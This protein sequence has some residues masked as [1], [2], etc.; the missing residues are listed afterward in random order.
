[1]ASIVQEK[2]EQA[3]GILQELR[4]DAWMTFVRETPASGDPVLPLIYGH[5][6]TWQSAIILTRSGERIAIIGQYEAETVHQTG[7]YPTVIPYHKSVR[8][9][10]LTVLDLLQPETIAINYSKNDVLADGLDHGL[11]LVLLDLLEGT[12]W[13]ERLISAEQVIAALRGRKTPTEV[14][15]IR[16]AVRTTAEIYQRTFDFVQVGM[17]EKQIAGFMH[18][19]MLAQGLDPAWELNN[20]PAVNAGPKSLMG[21]IGPSDI[22][23][24]RGHILHFDFGVRQQEYCADIQRVMYFLRS[25]ESQAPQP[26]QRGFDVIVRAI[27][28]AAAVMKPGI[29]GKQVDAV[30]R[31]VVTSAG[32]PE[33]MYGTGHHLGRLAHD[34]AGLLGPEWERY[35]NSPN[36]PLELGQ[37]Y[38]IEPGLEVPG[39]GY[40]GIEEDVIVTENGAEFL[41]LPQT[42][43]LLR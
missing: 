26:V 31:E 40:I 12:P 37:V 35:G 30:A 9:D 36:Y 18:E 7:A 1:M 34:G 2:V 3:I 16:Q 5:E 42:A 14:A 27:Q 43:L 11:Y 15:R 17:S 4:I 38:T 39:F 25:G 28:A 20:C 41:G 24:E 32:Y 21:H 29:L 6:L 23:L 19:Q 13:V 8:P 10:L 22:R 33:Y